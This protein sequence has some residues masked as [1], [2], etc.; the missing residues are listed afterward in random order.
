[1]RASPLPRFPSVNS[2]SSASWDRQSL[3]FNRTC[4]YSPRQGVRK[5]KPRSTIDVAPPLT[6]DMGP[7][8]DYM[9]ANDNSTRQPLA[10]VRRQFLVTACDAIPRCDSAMESEWSYLATVPHPLP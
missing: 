3:V 7:A 4:R 8:R 5:P 10:L 6:D 1:M 2:R 9:A